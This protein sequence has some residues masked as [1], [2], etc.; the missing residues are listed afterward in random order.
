MAL[1][2]RDKPARRDCHATAETANMSRP[3]LYA[4]YS[5]FLATKPVRSGAPGG[6]CVG[7]DNMDGSGS[8]YFSL[9]I[10]TCFVPV[11]KPAVVQHPDLSAVFALE[12]AHQLIA[13]PLRHAASPFPVYGM[14]YFTIWGRCLR[15]V[16]PYTFSSY[17]CSNW[18]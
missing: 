13:K 7:A 4:A 9:L 14:M 2:R 17:H 11:K 1:K 10:I 15:C 8:T 12:S 18:A 16:C 6:F 5:G 3:D